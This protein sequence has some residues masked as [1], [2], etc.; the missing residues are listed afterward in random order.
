M[1]EAGQDPAG[2]GSAAGT[3]A[4]HVG[5]LDA[6]E[7]G[8]L[9]ESVLRESTVGVAI[10]VGDGLRFARVS[11]SYRGLT[12][13]PDVDPVGRTFADVWGSIQPVEDT[14]RRVL[15]TG[16]PA[17][18]EEYPIALASGTRWYSLKVTRIS[19]GQA[20]ALLVFVA[21]QTALVLARTSA[22]EGLHHALR[23]AAELDA[24]I[25]SIADGFVHYGPGGEVLRLNASAA[26]I[27]RGAGVERLAS[28]AD[29]AAQLTLRT[30]EGRPL[31]LDQWPGARALRGETVTAMHLQVEAP[32]G[33]TG[34]I[35]ASAAPVRDPGGGVLGAVLT[36]SDESEVH[37]LEEERDDL[38]RMISHDLRTPLHAVY[39]QAHLL[40]RGPGDPEKVRDRAASIARSCER[41]SGMIQDLVET[42]LLEAGQLPLTTGPVDLAETVP[43]LLERLRDAVD[44]GRVHLAVAPGLVPVQADP[45]RLERILVNLLT[46]ALKYSPA[47]SPVEIELAP[48]PGGARV[49]VTD[50][51]IGIS[52]EDQAHVFDRFYRARGQRRPEGLGLGLYITRLLVEAHGG[53]IEVTS[54]LGQGSTFTVHL[55][56]AE[57]GAPL[58]PSFN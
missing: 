47:S 24:V 5:R 10:M 25:D 26:A 2:Q 33:R 21:E 50:R 23:R 54:A 8:A 51:G 30:P 45:P 19:Y 7:T 40:R 41:M 28:L 44:V 14:L 55:P 1:G 36:F 18:A 29:T 43:E 53:H 13:A 22:E 11:D 38:V 27:F 3:A 46:N 42:T 37:A 15:A 12:P 6:A 9:L 35:L 17:R 57:E 39:T 58:A 56:A 16:E 52:P 32:N 48:A 4:T 20:P 34:W 31:R 49:S